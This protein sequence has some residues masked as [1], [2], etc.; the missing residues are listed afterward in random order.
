MLGGVQILYGLGSY[1]GDP[2]MCGGFT[3]VDGVTVNNLA[4]WDGTAWQP[5]GTGTNG[6][7]FDVAEIDGRLYAAG[8]FTQAGGLPANRVAVW[9]GTSWSA[10]GG[11]VGNRVFALE[12]VGTDLYAAG[13][14]TT[15]DGQPAGYVAR[16]D[17]TTWHTLGSGLDAPGHALS[18]SGSKLWVGGE[19]LLAGTT[20]SSRVARW[21]PLVTSAVPVGDGRTR[22]AMA[23]PWP[24]PSVGSTTLAFRLPEAA[25]VV[26]DVFDVRGARIRTLDRPGLAA[27]PHQ[28][29][30]DG[31]DGAG[32][33]APSGVY[34]VAL[35]DGTSAAKRRVVLVR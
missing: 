17:G 7:V 23:A 5:F 15:A 20:G 29:T 1:Q 18:V 30:W 19:F 22:I 26:I 10:L 13:E 9:D 32:R 4:R 33:L 24:N 11:G 25:D 8:V 27:G 3:S 28:V 21:N 2:V 31:R 35:R 14:F 12:A 16:W 6:A 34:F